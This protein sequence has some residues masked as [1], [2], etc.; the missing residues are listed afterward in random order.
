[1]VFETHLESFLTLCM[2]GNF[3]SFCCRLLFQKI[4]SGAL[5]ECQ[6]VNIL[7]PDQVRNSVGL[8]LGLFAKVISR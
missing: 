7:D 3:S 8:D 2:L 4:L 6:T 1:M 5:S